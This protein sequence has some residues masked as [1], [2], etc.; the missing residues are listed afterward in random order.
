MAPFKFPINDWDG[1]G[2]TDDLYDIFMEGKVCENFETKKDYSLPLDPSIVDGV[3]Y[4]LSSDENLDEEDLEDLEITIELECESDYDWREDFKD[5]NTY[6]VSLYEYETQEEFLEAYFKAQE[7][8]SQKAEEE[9]Q[10]EI[11]KAEEETQKRIKEYE[12]KQKKY[13]LELDL[14]AQQEMKADIADR[15]EYIYCGVKFD[16]N[17]QIF[18]YITDDKSII[19][20]D[21]VI[22]PVGYDNKETP[23]IVVSVK[24]CRR[25]DAPYPFSNTKRI[26]RKI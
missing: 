24:N 23:A 2:S 1:N 11:E 20:G 22:V 25:V 5:C 13:Y 12:E 26:I 15:K 9:L 16:G 3:D 7:Q 10:K 6:G 14:K 21:T 8:Y 19:A 17:S 18:H 4:T